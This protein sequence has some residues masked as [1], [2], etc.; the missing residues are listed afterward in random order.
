MSSYPYD[1]QP[2]SETAIPLV[3]LSE[4]EDTD[5]YSTDDTTVNG[6]D[7][8]R[9]DTFDAREFEE[10][11]RIATTISRRRSLA[12]HSKSHASHTDRRLDPNHADFDLAT[13]LRRFIQQ[14]SAGGL[15]KTPVGFTFQN[16][17]VS[18]SGE[19]LQLQQTLG[20]VFLSPFRWKETFARGKHHR[21]ILNEF[22][23]HVNPGEMLVVL[24][25][26][27]SGCS[28]FLKSTCGELEGLKVEDPSSIRYSGISQKQM[29]KE[30]KGDLVY[31]QEVDKHFPHL[32]V[33][34]TLE[35]AAACR[36]PQ[37]RIEDTS[38]AEH[39]ESAVQVVMA[40][41]GLSHTR[42]TKVGNDFIRGV[43]G[44]ERKRVSIAEMIVA[45][46][47]IGAWDNR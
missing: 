44:G 24:G 40:M 10:L 13:W 35:F 8:A 26:P 14:M 43:S 34:E 19:A 32:T 11:E 28:T 38:R 23:A 39:I 5:D 21:R 22:N 36:T 31:N 9:R 17:S 46:S 42:N 1:G 25:R 29:V 2:V 6:A 41:C 15:E 3:E 45:G 18:G 12:I 27:G 47:S 4:R 37:T 33:G 20:D 7:L 30:F 16:L